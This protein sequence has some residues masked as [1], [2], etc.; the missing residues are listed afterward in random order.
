MT[1]N[2]RRRCFS[3]APRRRGLWYDR[4]VFRRLLTLAS[5][6]SLLLCLATSALWARSYFVNDWFGRLHFSPGVPTEDHHLWIE[7]NL[8]LLWVNWGGDPA[9]NFSAVRWELRHLPADPARRDYPMDEPP[10]PRAL[11]IGWEK[12][13]RLLTGETSAGVRV[14]LA[15]PA[16]AFA[17]VAIL[18]RAC[19]KRSRGRTDGLTCAV[20]GYDLR[21]TPDRCP[22]CGTAVGTKEATA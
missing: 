13:H 19:G 17:F 6:L 3:P 20:C 4:A 2:A 18:C 12:N 11:A 16:L 14:R 15:F 8:G 5:A 7:A 9:E 10:V 1:F 21:A 22:E